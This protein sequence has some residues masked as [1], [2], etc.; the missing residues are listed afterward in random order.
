MLRRRAATEI[1]A[2]CLFGSWRNAAAV[3]SFAR[4]EQIRVG[5]TMPRLPLSK[6]LALTF[7]A[8]VALAALLG[9]GTAE[10]KT[11]FKKAGVG[12]AL[13]EKLAQLQVDVMLLQATDWSIY[14]TY[15]SG[16][17][18][19]GYSFGPRTYKCKSEAVGW[20][21]HGQATLCKL[22]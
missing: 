4:T 9:A 18:T 13:T 5:N 20:Q 11:C 16:N 2:L 8:S 10:A 17:G 3:P 7:G 12:N 6:S 21:C 19:P 1:A 15:I 22:D 14:F